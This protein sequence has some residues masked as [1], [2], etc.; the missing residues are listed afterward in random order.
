MQSSKAKMMFEAHSKL[1]GENILIKMQEL[2]G[3][4]AL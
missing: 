1:D 2:K 4:S 3:N